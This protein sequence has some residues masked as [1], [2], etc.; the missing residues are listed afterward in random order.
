MPARFEADHAGLRAMLGT[1]EMVAALHSFADVIEERAV[2]ISPI[3]TGRYVNS[4]RVTSGVRNGVA[5]SRVAN[6]APYAGFLETGTRYMKRQRI[7][8]RAVDAVSAR[9]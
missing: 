2:Q 9:G 6:I 3:R 8:G 4:W 5:W 7:L 1:P